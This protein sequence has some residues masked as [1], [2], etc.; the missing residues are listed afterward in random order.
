LF[1][2]RKAFERITQRI[3]S[4]YGSSS[5]L[6]TASGT[7]ALA[8]AFLASAKRGRRPR[9]ALP[10]WGCYDMMTAADTA[11]AEVF[12]YDLDPLRLAPD[13]ASLTR[14]LDQRLDAV[15]VAHW[16]G[17]PVDLRRVRE[18]TR[19]PGILLIDD[20]AQGVAASLAG[21]PVGAGGDF[22]VLS[23]GRGKGRTGGS[24]GGLLASSPEAAGRL[25]EVA[26]RL[27]PSRT[28]LTSY[29][30]LW[31]QLGLG[32]PALYWIPARIP[33]FRLG[34]TVYHPSPE[35]RRMA[36]PAAAVLDSVWEL[37]LR[38]AEVRRAGAAR[39]ALAL[40]DAP[41]ITSVPQD[42][43]IF[44]GWL[45]YPFLA[46]EVVRRRIA[47]SRADRYGVVP[48]YP[49]LLSDLPVKPGRICSGLTEFPG[50]ERLAHS[51]FTLPTH[52][53]VTDR[54][55]QAVVNLFGAKP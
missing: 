24:G 36:R 52:R 26:H 55:F 27:L 3:H 34:Q 40:A 9:I 20:A 18:T 10:A 42:P 46:E 43:G 37:S 35:L 51:L 19:E 41:G 22:G 5:I 53:L 16:F 7:V 38:E 23:F 28:G 15:V 29:A 6:L 48:G 4:E 39:W 44:S 49:G 12:L 2:P 31:A 30:L 45:R 50:A 21:R 1:P 47:E 11:D 13:P 33:W 17:M 32:R 54:D 14:I 8:L 25:A